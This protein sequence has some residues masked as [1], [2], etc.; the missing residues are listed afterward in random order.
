[1]KSLLKILSASLILTSS[2]MS[3]AHATLFDRGNGMIYDSDQD[4]TWLQDAN[5]AKTTGHGIDGAMDWYTATEWADNLIYGGFDDWRLP[6]INK[7]DTSGCNYGYN[8][9]TN[10]GYGVDT[11]TSELAYLWHDILGNE[12]AVDYTGIMS[13]W[14]LE[15]LAPNG[16]KFY[17][18]EIS[19]YWSGTE[20]APDTDFAWGFDNFTTFQSAYPKLGEDNVKFAWAVRSGDVITSVPEPGPL[21]LLSLG[22]LI[23]TGIKARQQ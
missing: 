7:N 6:S 10:C 3:T 14:G 4:L 23:F 20:Y 22:L 15:Y 19:Y 11:S 2:I 1:M 12:P 18:L 5:Y 21:F 8:L 17:N 13:G 16:V 9:G